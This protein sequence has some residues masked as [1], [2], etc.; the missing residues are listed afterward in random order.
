[1]SCTLLASMWT[2]VGGLMHRRQTILTTVGL[3]VNPQFDTLGRHLTVS[4]LR[5]QLHFTFYQL[6]FYI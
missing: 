4:L 6:P 5:Y 2:A 1:M 3:S